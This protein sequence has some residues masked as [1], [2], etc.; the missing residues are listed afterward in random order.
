MYRLGAPPPLR[1]SSSR[2]GI[3]LKCM[4]IA[5]KKIHGDSVENESARA[6]QLEGGGATNAPPLKPV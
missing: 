3:G 2:I 5:V 4:F 6:K 1:K